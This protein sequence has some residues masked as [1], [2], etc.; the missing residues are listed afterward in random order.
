MKTIQQ[1][2]DRVVVL[3]MEGN[4]DTPIVTVTTDSRAVQPGSLFIAIRGTVHDGHEHLEQVITNGAI[5]L[6]IDGDYIVSFEIPASVVVVRVPNTAK[7]LALI[8]ANWH[9]RPA[10]QLKIIGV[11]GTNGKTSVCTMLY[12]LFMSLGIKAGL[13]ST[14]SVKI[15]N[16]SEPAVLTTPDPIALHR[17]F[18][19]MLSQG[20][21]YCFMEVSSHALVQDRVFGIPFQMAVFTN[22]THDHLDYHQTFANYLAAKQILFNHLQA[23]AIALTNIDDPNGLIMVQNAKAHILQYSLEL[24]ANYTAKLIENQLEGMLVEISGNQIW[25]Q[26]NGL[27]NAYN[28]LAVYGV[29]YEML[30]DRGGIQYAP[31]FDEPGFFAIDLLTAMSQLRPV[32][33]RFQ[34]I[35]TAQDYFIVIDYAHTPDALENVLQTIADFGYRKRIIVVVGCGGNRDRS[36]RPIM[37]K[38]ACQWADKV[39]LTSDN[40]RDEDPN[41]I[42]AEM[43]KGIPHQYLSKVTVEPLRQLAIQQ[44][45]AEAK[46]RDIILIAGKG[47]EKYQEIAGVK[48]P[49]DDVQVAM[50]A[51]NSLNH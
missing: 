22:I 21:R 48:Y 30:I 13:I 29:A 15:G 5:G 10:D 4:P 25:F 17:Y 9:D 43:T 14:V 24:P 1:L 42:L 36:K 3:H 11:T 50:E 38:T 27:F 44:A 6:I 31:Q 20:C 23:N 49:F 8:A 7:A 39:Y 18:Q 51:V 32:E 37:A 19:E 28:L 47:H 33:G 40:P 41:L 12:E 35:R 34:T 16:H 46:A 45:I 2:L 26:L